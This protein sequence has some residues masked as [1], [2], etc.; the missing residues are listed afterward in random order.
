[1]TVSHS[2]DIQKLPHYIPLVPLDLLVQTGLHFLVDPEQK[3]MPSWTTQYAKLTALAKIHSLWKKFKNA[4]KMGLI[5][6]TEY[7]W[8]DKR[9]KP[10]KTENMYFQTSSSCNKSYPC[11]RRSNRAEWTCSANRALGRRKKHLMSFVTLLAVSKCS[12]L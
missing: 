2:S 8:Q 7:I 9:D 6:P 10:D 5:Q 3:H 4:L 11:S 12:F 1:M